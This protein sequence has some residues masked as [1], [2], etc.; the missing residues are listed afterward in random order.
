MTQTKPTS[1]VRL[2]EDNAEA[3]LSSEMF[4]DRVSLLPGDSG[5]IQAGQR[6]RIPWGQDMLRDLLD[7]R[8]R[9]VICGVNDADNSHGII[10]QLVNLVTTSQWS[11]RSVTS[12]AKMFQ[13]SVSV[14]AAH[15]KEPYILKYDL[16][17]LLILA[18]LKPKGRDFLTLQDLARGFTTIT[19]MLQGRADRRPVCSVSFLGARSNRLVNESD[20]ARR[21]R[22]R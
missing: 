18:V 13:E 5:K 2:Y 7:G 6:I 8:Y 21:A 15:D 14:H 19:K 16:D 11:E 4:P 20:H 3:L 22:R 9:T 1:E 10:A 17:S 12:Y